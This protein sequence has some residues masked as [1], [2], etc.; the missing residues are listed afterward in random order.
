MRKNDEARMTNVEGMT[1]PR[2]ALAKTREEIGR[3]FPVMRE[4]RTHF[5]DEE[6]FT[7]QVVRQQGDGYLLAFLEAEGEIRAV[8]GYRFLESLF[9]GRVLY[10]DDLVTRESDRS[11]GFG[12]E[13][14]DWLMEEARSRGCE[15]LELDSGVQRFDAHRFY[16][17]KR[18]N[19]SSYHFRIKTT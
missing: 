11:R 13:L 8:A 4:L 2:I 16:L 9:A 18:M 17:L 3:C 19:I 12:G 5:T 10:V 15:N 1:K 14:F 6:K 7:E